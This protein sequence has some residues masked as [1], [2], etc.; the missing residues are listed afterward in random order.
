MTSESQRVHL[1][2]PHGM[3]KC[4]RLHRLANNLPSRAAK[5]LSNMPLS[6]LLW[7][8]S[9]SSCA[10]SPY[11]APYISNKIYGQ[12]SMPKIAALCVSE[13]ELVFLRA[14]Q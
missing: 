4:T 5:H 6:A 13:S 10:L 12:E 11:V 8:C 14:L 9:S 7:D 3:R 1:L 2:Q